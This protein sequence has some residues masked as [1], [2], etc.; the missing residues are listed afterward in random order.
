MKCP[1]CHRETGDRMKVCSCGFDF[2]N[3]GLRLLSPMRESVVSRIEKHIKP[4]PGRSLERPLCTIESPADYVAYNSEKNGSSMKEESLAP[5]AGFDNDELGTEIV[6]KNGNRYIGDVQNGKRHG[7]GMM[8]YVSGNCIE[9]VWENDAFSEELTSWRSD[10]SYLR[11]DHMMWRTLEQDYLTEEEKVRVEK[12]LQEEFEVRVGHC[13]GQKLTAE[14][15]FEFEQ[16]EDVHES[17]K[18]LQAHVP[19]YG[20]TVLLVYS[21]LKDEIIRD[22]LNGTGNL[23]P[24]NG[25]VQTS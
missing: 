19:G 9:G 13:I 14:E 12:V 23:I 5:V 4:L 3:S 8:K 18:W 7:I 21:E 16:I 2:K 20:K 11:F 17:A 6:Y 22:W 24:R 1:K 10:C 25:E 15:R